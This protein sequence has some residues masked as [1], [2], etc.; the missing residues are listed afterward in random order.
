MNQPFNPVNI[1]LKTIDFSECKGDERFLFVDLGFKVVSEIKPGELIWV[2]DNGDW[3]LWKAEDEN[4]LNILDEQVSPFIRT[5]IEFNVKA[6]A[7]KNA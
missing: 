4:V 3:C 6:E 2:R 7:A 1:E 5:L